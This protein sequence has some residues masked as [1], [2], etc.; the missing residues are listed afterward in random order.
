MLVAYDWLLT[1]RRLECKAISNQNVRYLK[2]KQTEFT[3]YR[4]RPAH[5][6]SDFVKKFQISDC[7]QQ[8]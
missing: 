4:H 7:I 5:G 8:L 2:A 3:A 1:I 6:F